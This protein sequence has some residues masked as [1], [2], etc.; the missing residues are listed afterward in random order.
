M[1]RSRAFTLVEMLTVVIII[2][3]LLGLGVAIGPG[4]LGLGEHVETKTTL[5][6]LE[7]INAEYKS[8]TGF[9]VP[10]D[11]VAIEADA[12]HPWNGRFPDARRYWQYSMQYFFSA[13]RDIPT[14]ETIYAKIAPVERKYTLYTPRDVEQD[15]TST[16]SMTSTS[17]DF[18]ASDIADAWG[19]PILY[20]AQDSIGSG[21][22]NA[23]FI[24]DKGSPYFVS[25]GPDGK[26]GDALASDQSKPV[27]KVTLDNIFSDELL[28]SN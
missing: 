6:N 5:K 15:A 2:L 10:L 25:A 16:V 3:I 24:P 18:V 23:D 26:I 22:P 14:T 8:L 20:K 7:L 19:L 1:K 4:M 21:N 28:G 27:F 9:P 12:A 13:T 17:G 11:P